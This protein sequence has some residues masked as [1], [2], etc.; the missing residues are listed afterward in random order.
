M[1]ADPQGYVAG[2]SGCAGK[3]V[4]VTG[5]AEGLGKAMATGFARAGAR[6]LIADLN[7]DGLAETARE[8]GGI[9]SDIASCRTDVTS[10]ADVEA[11]FALAAEHFGGVDVLVN[12][13]G[14]LISSGAPETYS[15][16]DWQATLAVN[17]NGSYLCAQAAGRLM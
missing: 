15:F 14:A 8:L 16:Q 9:T 2:L 17:L 5:A 13:A 4:I 12:N 10:V 7:A 1:S 6:V 3:R 11:L